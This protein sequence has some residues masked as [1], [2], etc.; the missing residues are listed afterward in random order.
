M[1]KRIVKTALI[2]FLIVIGLLILLL[3]FFLYRIPYQV[4]GL[5]N[6]I[7]TEEARQLVNECKITKIGEP[8]IG[9]VNLKLI[10]GSYKYIEREQ[11]K[12]I[13]QLL[14]AN[15]EKCGFQIQFIME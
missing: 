5:L 13:S 7:T 12:E 15:Q 9:K 11:K 14:L 3:A 10:D 6:K 1:I 4:D 8:H 2:T